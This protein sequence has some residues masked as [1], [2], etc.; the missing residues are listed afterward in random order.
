MNT[1]QNELTKTLYLTKEEAKRAADESGKKYYQSSAT[2][3][4][5]EETDCNIV[6]SG[7]VE[8][9]RT[10]DGD[11][12]AWYYDLTEEEV[13]KYY[14]AMYECGSD[15]AICDTREESAWLATFIQDAQHVTEYTESDVT[16][17]DWAIMKE[18]LELSE[19]KVKR[20]HVGLN[21]GIFSFCL[22]EDWE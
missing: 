22:N 14:G 19:N 18:Q 4:N 21:G 1:N 11:V 10:D 6:W 15:P 20:I 13:N 7:E 8:C 9:Y 2:E 5:I 16:A 3:S 12:F 17:E